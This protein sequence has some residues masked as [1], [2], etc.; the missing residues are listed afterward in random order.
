MPSALSDTVIR[1]NVRA[2]L[3]ASDFR[4]R[5]LDAGYVSP[6]KVPFACITCDFFENH[7]DATGHCRAREVTAE[8]EPYG[9]CDYWEHDGVGNSG[10]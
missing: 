5:L 8:V 4:K 10:K 3:G 1:I 9:C 2:G 7:G 6:Q